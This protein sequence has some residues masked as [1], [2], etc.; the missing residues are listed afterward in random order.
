MPLYP[1]N[2]VSYEA[3]PQLLALPLFPPQTHL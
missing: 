3:C 1:Q 2:A